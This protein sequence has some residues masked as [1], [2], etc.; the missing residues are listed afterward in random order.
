M[1]AESATEAIYLALSSPEP[2]PRVVHAAIEE[3]RDLSGQNV[4]AVLG[5]KI[6]AL[7]AR[8]DAQSTR[9]DALSARIDAQIA[10]VKAEIK[11]QSERI[12]AQSERIDAQS[13]R[14]DLLQR[15]IWR[16]IWPL[17]ALVAAPVLGL[18]YQ[19]LSR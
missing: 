17:V 11:A 10:E 7:G 18:L 13:E 15:V 4:I 14:I 2:D 8:I 1:A 5:A 6:D 9:I 19:A 16:V 3:I 12:D